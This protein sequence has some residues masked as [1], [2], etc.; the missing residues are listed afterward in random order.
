MK[1]HKINSLN[2][3]NKIVSQKKIIGYGAPAKATTILN[4]YGLTDSQIEY[5][6]DDN[7]LKQG[8]FIPGT[9][10][11]IIAPDNIELTKFDYVLVL[12]WN[13]F[14]QIQ[15]KLSSTFKTSQFI[16]LK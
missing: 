6:L 5:T 3:I 12:A 11:Q 15:E 2:K 13:F 7:E 14:N 10:I 1:K 9:K 4:Y 16:K 8:K